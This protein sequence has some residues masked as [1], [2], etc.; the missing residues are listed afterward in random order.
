MRD[1]ARLNFLIDQIYASLYTGMNIKDILGLISGNSLE[2]LDQIDPKAEVEIVRF[3]IRRR[4][5]HLLTRQLGPSH[6]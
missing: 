5:D 4:I 6:V 2:L 3:E 1:T